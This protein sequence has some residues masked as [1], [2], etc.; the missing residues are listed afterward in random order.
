MPGIMGAMAR[1]QSGNPP[2][3]PEE[4]RQPCHIAD[5]I[6]VSARGKAPSEQLWQAL[7]LAEASLK[8]TTAILY[9]ALDEVAP[10]EAVTVLSS[11]NTAGTWV[12]CLRTLAK[13]PAIWG[14]RGF[15]DELILW[16]S[17]DSVPWL[18]EAMEDITAVLAMLQ[19][20]RT[21]PRRPTVCDL[22]DAL[23]NV[24]N[25]RAH[26]GL[27][28]ATT[29]RAAAKLCR[30]VA[31]R[32]VGEWPCHGWTWAL[33]SEG[34]WWSL[35]AD[36]RC[37]VS[38]EPLSPP[39]P[40]DAIYVWKEDEPPLRCGKLLMAESDPPRILCLNSSLRQNGRVEY[41]EYSTD[42]RLRERLDPPRTR[43]AGWLTDVVP[44]PLVNLVGRDGVVADLRS[45]LERE[46]LVT[47]VGPSG[48][49]KTSVAAVAVGA[50]KRE[51]AEGV[52]WCHCDRWPLGRDRL[53]R[54]VVPIL[55]DSASYGPTL[56]LLDSLEMVLDSEG[57]DY[58]REEIGALCTEHPM[59]RIL[60]TSL[61]PL[62]VPGEHQYPLDPL[63]T[64]P[65]DEDVAL[66]DLTTYPALGLLVD[67]IR[68][69]RPD[70]RVGRD[71]ADALCEIA[72]ALGGHPL[73][74]E[75]IGP[76]V[77]LD[78]APGVAVALASQLSLVERDRGP[79]R[80]RSV[81]SAVAYS[82]A[83]LCDAERKVLAVSCA[84]NLTSWSLLEATT[85][86]CGIGLA[87]MERAMRRLQ[88]RCLVRRV[89]HTVIG[90]HAIIQRQ[91]MEE[92]GADGMIAF[93]Q[94]AAL[95]VVA[96]WYERNG[97]T[98]HSCTC[99]TCEV[100]DEWVAM[101]YV[102]HP[103]STGSNAPRE[104]LRLARHWTSVQVDKGG[105]AA[106]DSW[107]SEDDELDGVSLLDEVL[108]ATQAW[109]GAE[110]L[111]VRVQAARWVLD[112]PLRYEGR[113]ARVCPVAD[114]LH[115][116][117]RDAEA[118]ELL[119][120]CI[121][122]TYEA[123]GASAWSEREDLFEGARAVIVRQMRWA[124]GRKDAQVRA[125]ACLRY[126]RWF[127]DCGEMA[128]EDWRL[129]LRKARAVS[130][131]AL[132][133]AQQVGD[134]AGAREAVLS[135]DIIEYHLVPQADRSLWALETI[136]WVI[137]SV[138]QGP[139]PV[140]VH[141]QPEDVAW[142]QN[143]R[144]QLLLRIFGHL[145]GGLEAYTAECLTSAEEA[146]GCGSWTRAAEWLGRA[147]RCGVPDAEASE[148][149]ARIH[150]MQADVEAHIGRGATTMVIIEAEGASPD[151][152][153]CDLGYW[154]PGDRG[155]A[156]HAT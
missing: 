62:A 131:R 31:M 21:P 77:A 91:L 56:L 125:R 37:Q 82:L 129:H 147:K 128:E 17:E 130:R 116:A 101:E 65:T 24:R 64:V 34:V 118:L 36:E 97:P 76:R 142:E 12:A 20:P 40:Q 152:I 113:V 48:L 74:L 78:G 53:E 60:A 135:Q 10:Q 43:R 9:G 108:A 18:G 85:T 105:L 114:S 11:L 72:R 93:A 71:D 81:A 123:F 89:G 32:L 107:L 109:D 61:V 69:V 87:T 19:S 98:A 14:R 154:L 49:G 30:S 70:Y 94:R 155:Y 145:D 121:A 134:V 120:E 84:L 59:L 63:T 139:Q 39:P 41:L 23:V 80:H 151:A 79:E 133:W 136:A 102:K 50:L 96:G 52:F 1:P 45:L 88:L 153:L 38:A 140:T 146:I 28:P 103:E 115:I 100:L 66:E 58:I 132:A 2:P 13:H 106:S 99:S 6:Q 150:Q 73:A 111:A 137:H 51:G 55:R 127:L 83:S 29:L 44:A 86:E 7:N 124:E 117:D 92:N 143:G 119:E 5:L 33:A 46:R 4:A 68:D 67:R 122:G 15:L 35:Q 75:I 90:P 141:D 148:W 8:T 47:V 156:E 57:K 26:S 27:T 16:L 22:L 95:N 25:L 138:E 104:L 42:R 149:E 112:D 110:A 54:E 3:P 126:L 144:V